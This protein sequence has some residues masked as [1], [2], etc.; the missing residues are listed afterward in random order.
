MPKRRQNTRRY[1][2]LTMLAFREGK[3]LE[4]ELVKTKG[5]LW[6]LPDGSF[7]GTKRHWK[8][9]EQIRRLIKRGAIAA[10]SADYLVP[11]LS[12]KTP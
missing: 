3:N 6:R 2:N 12:L 4:I 10:K 8:T 7:R 11:F 9:P 1:R 5:R